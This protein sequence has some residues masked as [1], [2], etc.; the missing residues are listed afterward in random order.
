MQLLAERKQCF[1]KHILFI[2]LSISVVGCPQEQVSDSSGNSQSLKYEEYIPT[3]KENNESGADNEIIFNP[4]TAIDI[5]H[6]SLTLFLGE[7]TRLEATA[8]FAD[9]SKLDVTSIATWEYT[10]SDEIVIEQRTDLKIKAQSTGSGSLSINYEGFESRIPVEVISR[11]ITKLSIDFNSPSLG[12]RKKL[13][14]KAIYAD[15]SEQDVTSRISWTVSNEEILHLAEGFITPIQTGEATL[16]AKLGQLTSKKF[17]EIVAPDNIQ[18]LAIEPPAEN[19]IPF[20]DTTTFRAIAAL[21]N[22]DTLDVTNWVKWSS[23]QTS[24][25][26]MS[27]RYEEKGVASG[28]GVGQVQITARLGSFSAQSV[29]QVGFGCV[30]LEVLPSDDLNLYLTIEQSITINCVLSDGTRIDKTSDVLLSSDAVEIEIDSTNDEVK[31]IPRAITSGSVSIDAD[32]NSITKTINVQVFDKPLRGIRITG[33]PSYSF[34]DDTQQTQ[35]QAIGTF[36]EGTES[37]ERNI[38]ETANW[39]TEDQ[40]SLL[41]DNSSGSK[42]LLTSLKAGTYVLTAT[43]LSH[44]GQSFTAS[45]D[46]TFSDPIITGFYSKLYSFLGNS[47]AK[48]RGDEISD[49]GIGAPKGKR[50]TMAG[51]L[52]M[53]CGS[54]V[55][56]TADNSRLIWSIDQPGQATIW[57]SGGSQIVAG[58]TSSGQFSVSASFDDSE[59]T[60]SQSTTFN[61][62]PAEV[63]GLD[64]FFDDE[65]TT[66]AGINTRFIVELGETTQLRAMAI[67]SDDSTQDVTNAV[68]VLANGTGGADNEHYLSIAWSSTDITRASVSS[69]TGLATAVKAGKTT[70]SAILSVNY[71]D[72]MNFSDQSYEAALN[73][74]DNPKELVVVN[75]CNS[76]LRYQYYC[77][78]L[79]NNGESC[80]DVCGSSHVDLDGTISLNSSTNMCLSVANDP[81]FNLDN[82]SSI[83]TFSSLSLGCVFHSS[84][85]NLYNTSTPTAESSAPDGRRFCSCF[86]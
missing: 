74:F 33:T 54:D 79:G 51:F 55:D 13:R 32:F 39:S 23:M 36:G 83:L 52:E 41:V 71:T 27:N 44:D 12:Q 20:Q 72:S 4:V 15:H 63:V 18:S 46:F 24:R 82:F 53:S 58:T 38:T 49:N 56:I 17:V 10:G 68:G 35:L 19:F 6:D 2:V 78:Y 81:A 11:E 73:Q 47:S 70:M 3:P 28:I 5:G 40:T 8:L 14:V 62:W 61:N 77:I 66:I 65:L 85:G 42:G 16:T 29:L 45:L 76:G 9:G 43:A 34:C 69:T 37:E 30:S 67:F 26:T 25:A 86:E 21:E 48:F 1:F 59:N 84:S 7:F 60:F 80:N 75:P 64:V 31:I 57:E 22:G 50:F